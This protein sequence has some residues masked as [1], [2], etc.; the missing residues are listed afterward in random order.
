[1]ATTKGTY[2]GS[3]YGKTKGLS[4]GGALSR[5]L[6]LVFFN[7]VAGRLQE[8]RARVPPPKECTHLIYADDVPR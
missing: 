4:Q 1:M 8:L 7:P 5:L 2:H 3:I 6:W